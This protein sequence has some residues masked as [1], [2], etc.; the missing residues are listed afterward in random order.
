ML[1]GCFHPFSDHFKIQ[2]TRQ[3]DDCLNDG[4]IFRIHRLNERLIDFK[5]VDRKTTE[6]AQR[7]ISGAKIV[8]TQLHS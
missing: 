5:G 3:P 2:I 6:I 7:G 1:V 4:I 8:D